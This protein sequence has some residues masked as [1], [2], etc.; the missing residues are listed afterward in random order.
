[1]WFSVA[2]QETGEAH[3]K[4]KSAFGKRRNCAKYLSVIPPKD[5]T[6]LREAVYRSD[7]CDAAGFRDV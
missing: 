7:E 1:M 4:R 3:L 5:V 2:S 6:V